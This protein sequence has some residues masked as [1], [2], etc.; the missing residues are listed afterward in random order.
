MSLLTPIERAKI[1]I[2]G[3]VERKRLRCWFLHDWS[4]WQD[5]CYGQIAV[6]LILKGHWVEQQRRCA[7]CG[8]A[9]LKMLQAKI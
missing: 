3:F 6:G 7:A 2:T 9:Q 1:G 4:K 5:V 8:K